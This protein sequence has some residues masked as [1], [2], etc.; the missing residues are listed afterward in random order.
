M[1]W[2][3]EA[4]GDGSDGDGE[5]V[6]A[7][8]QLSPEALQPQWQLDR[9]TLQVGHAWLPRGTAPIDPLDGALAPGAQ[10]SRR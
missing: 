7:V 4:R 8:A 5:A 9:A 1:L 6:A 2:R 3:Q 10:P